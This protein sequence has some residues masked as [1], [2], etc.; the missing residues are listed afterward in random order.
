MRVISEPDYIRINSEPALSR[1]NETFEP[2]R[3][4]KRVRVS[5]GNK[6]TTG[7][8]SINMIDEEIGT[9]KSK[10]DIKESPRAREDAS[11]RDNHNIERTLPQSQ[12]LHQ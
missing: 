5:G 12:I 7:N 10:T 1:L 3:I 2:R 9:E 4:G 11:D 8:E 6:N